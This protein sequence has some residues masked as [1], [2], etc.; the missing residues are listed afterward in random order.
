MV[1]RSNSSDVAL[2]GDEKA[3]LVNDQ[4]RRWRR[5]GDELVEGFIQLLNVLLDE[6][7]QSSHGSHVTRI[8]ER[9]G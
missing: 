5:S 1:V 9:F 3:A 4:R 8:G 6:L 2:V 7:R